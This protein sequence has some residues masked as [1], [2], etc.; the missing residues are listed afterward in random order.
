MHI[1]LSHIF[2]NHRFTAIPGLFERQCLIMHSEKN[3]FYLRCAK[4]TEMFTQA[5]TSSYKLCNGRICVWWVFLLYMYHADQW[6][7]ISYFW[8]WNS[9]AYPCPNPSWTVLRKASHGEKIRKLLVHNSDVIM[10]PMVSQITSLSIVYSTIC[11]CVDH[12]KH[13]SSASLAFVQ[14]IHRWPVNSPH[15]GP[16]TRKTFPFDDIIMC[17][18]AT[19]W[20]P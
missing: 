8:L 4:M 5:L 11:S 2:L 10:S 3:A 17:V 9:I 6:L 20:T 7:T 19:A 14:G 1:N 15:K 18:L 13:Q 12:R 16:V